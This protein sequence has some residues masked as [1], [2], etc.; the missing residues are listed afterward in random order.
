MDYTTIYAIYMTVAMFVVGLWANRVP[1][2]DVRTVFL[3][4][5]AWPVSILAILFM[6]LLNASGWDLDIVNGA[7]R[8][9]FRRPTNPKAKGW[10][11][12]VFGKEVQVYSMRKDA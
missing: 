10:A 12:T 5:V 3:L 8:F 9:G 7:T 11:V 1:Y 4:A 6:V 2:E